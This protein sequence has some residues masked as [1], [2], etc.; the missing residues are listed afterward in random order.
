[1]PYR[2]HTDNMNGIQTAKLLP[3]TEAQQID[4]REEVQLSL[5]DF[6]VSFCAFFD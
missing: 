6:R 3:V 1:M 4:L 5:T 2:V